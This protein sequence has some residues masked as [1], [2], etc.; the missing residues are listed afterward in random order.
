M[1]R[2]PRHYKHQKVA[3]VTFWWHNNRK[4]WHILWHLERFVEWET[5]EDSEKRFLTAFYLGIERY[6][7]MPEHM[8]IRE[9]KVMVV[10][11]M[12]K[13]WKFNLQVSKVAD[14][15][16]G[17]D[18]K[19][20]WWLHTAPLVILENLLDNSICGSDTDIKFPG[21]NV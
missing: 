2:W 4:N 6:Q 13:I 19:N 11:A 20:L 21:Q 9:S 7:H 17:C 12:L 15:M 10:W 3:A 8:I 18:D 1:N 14:A 16:W 5:E